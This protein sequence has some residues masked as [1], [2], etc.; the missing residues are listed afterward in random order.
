MFLTKPLDD[1]S[2]AS[3]Q[4]GLTLSDEKLRLLE[5]WMFGIRYVLLKIVS[6]LFCLD[7]LDLI[8]AKV[9]KQH[10]ASGDSRAAVV[11]STAPL[12]V[13]AY[14]DDLDCV[15]MLRFPRDFARRHQ[16]SVGSKLLSIN[17]YYRGFTRQ[18]DLTFGP[19]QTADWT[20]L[21]PVI[22][23]F[24]SDDDRRI[25]DHKQEIDET[26]WQRCRELGEAYLFERPRVARNGRPRRSHQ[27]AGA[28]KEA[29]IAFTV[30]G[31]V[32][33]ASCVFAWSFL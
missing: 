21:F 33:I 32:V 3:Q 27:P 7:V 15:A 14:S 16:L 30:A 26:E 20:G 22:A 25:E 13:A 8:N 24:L 2:T 19:N 9:L 18:A 23:E 10:L 5:P 28:V 31:L 4:G 29:V 12:L 11:V 6:A 1:P 17:T